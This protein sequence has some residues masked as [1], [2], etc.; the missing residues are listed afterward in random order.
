MKTDYSKYYTPLA[1]SKA[2][3][4][5]V[6]FKDD[7]A[8]VDI[9]CGSGNLLRAAKEK[10][11]TLICHGAD[12]NGISIDNMVI[13]KIDGRAYALRHKLS[14]DY[15]LANPPFGR[16]SS[17]KYSKRLFS[18]EYAAISSSRIEIE[19]LIAN[20][21]ILKE[22][23]TLLAILPT[24]IIDGLSAINIRKT[25]AAK[26]TISAIVDLPS[27]AFCPEKIKCS[28]IV[29]QKRKNQENFPTTLYNMD[30]EYQI[31]HFCEIS[32]AS[33]LAGN[34]TGVDAKKITSF[35]IRQG[36]FSSQEFTDHGEDVLHTGKK[37]NDWQPT[38][39][40]IKKIASNRARIK[41]EDGDIIISRIGA[42]AGQKCIYHGQPKYISDCLLIIKRPN[43]IVSSRILALDF[44]M[45]T[46]GLSTPHVTA[47]SIYDLYG[48]M[49][50]E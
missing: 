9:C 46:K 38:I 29:M 21:I 34:W 11:N 17:K 35:S 14:F 43:E 1:I 42:S 16:N 22:D 39:R 25:L 31:N 15:A 33:I 32:S 50:P 3:M 5:L 12:I 2:L 27:N 24:T 47:Q 6:G 7:S 23:G 8:V 48:N 40:H 19:M 45:L 26:H 30:C 36:S 18:K 37:T 49:Y 20:L 10:N 13:Q 4:Q 41:A 44:T 28:A